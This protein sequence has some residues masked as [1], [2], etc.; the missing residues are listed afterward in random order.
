M[1]KWKCCAVF[2]PY[3]LPVRLFCLFTMQWTDWRGWR[4]D[5]IWRDELNGVCAA[6]AV[7]V[8]IFDLADWRF[9]V[10]VVILWVGSYKL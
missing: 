3:L 7:G 10:F 8:S 5:Q 2:V 6:S 1:P 9:V 4:W